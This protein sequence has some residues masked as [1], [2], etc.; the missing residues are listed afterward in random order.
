ML[1]ILKAVNSILLNDTDIHNIV[2]D[3]I[4]PDV[5]PDKDASGVNIDYPL[6]IMRRVNIDIEYSKGCSTDAADVMV[7]CYANSYFDAVDLADYVRTALDSYKGV[8]EGINIGDVRLVEAEEDYV[9]VYYQQL[10]F[11]IR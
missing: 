10:L 8:V 2:G 1:K 11:E 3:K 6:I 4:F 5:V 9:D 7:I